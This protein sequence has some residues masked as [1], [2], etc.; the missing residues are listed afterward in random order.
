MVS[1]LSIIK[2]IGSTPGDTASAEQARVEINFLDTQGFSQAEY[3]I[4]LPPTK[5][6]VYA[7]SPTADG[8]IPVTTA[9]NNVTET[10]RMTL[11]A[12]SI[13]QLAHMMSQLNR[14][15]ADCRAFWDTDGQI[16]PVYIEHQVEGEPGPRFALLFNIDIDPGTEPS[17]PSAPMRDVTITIEREFGW[18][19]IRPGGNPKEW[20]YYNQPGQTFDSNH[21]AMTTGSD[22]ILTQS[23][24]NKREWNAAQTALTSQNHLLIPA[25]KIPGDLPALAYVSLTID[26][27]GGSGF[28]PDRILVG[29]SIKPDI[30]PRSGAQRTP[31]YILN[32]GDSSTY[33]ADTT[34]VA[35]T[36]A[37]RSGAS[38]AQLRGR[39]TFGTPADTARITWNSS[40]RGYVDGTLTRGRYIVFVRA[41]LSAGSSN[42]NLH[43]NI[44]NSV[45]D[46]VQLPTVPLTAQG[47]GGTGNTT[48]W[49]LCY[50]GVLTIPYGTNRALVSKSG[51]GLDVSTTASGVNLVLWAALTSGAAELYVSDLIL[52]PVDEAACGVEDAGT[53]GIGATQS[54][55]IDGTGYHTH[56]R[57][58]DD[59]MTGYS[60]NFV[61]PA[62]PSGQAIT[63]TPGVDNRLHFL[64][65]SSTNSALDMTYTVRVDIVPRW[66]GYRDI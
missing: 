63:L 33:G 10:I 21:A 39:V 5:A 60:T 25:A 19:G 9:V 24:Q 42:V 13:L 49:S 32:A 64:V 26:D 58:E 55:V 28:S 38:A 3:D 62:I 45:G 53:G 41:R 8:R 31:N 16:E 20:T 7:D 23:L 2:G 4:K 22:H 57:P 17:T 30:T 35:D 61:V 51:L 36:G 6:G 11:T 34:A 18:R 54:F 66:S 48:Y 52:I 46:N 12:A 27:P 40:H 65:N 29:R 1:R 50:L 44:N 43:L 14:M 37:P 59:F 47:G 56:G 15:A